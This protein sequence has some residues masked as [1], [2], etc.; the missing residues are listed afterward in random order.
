MNL[1]GNLTLSN[2][3]N[4]NLSIYFTDNTKQYSQIFQ[5]DPDPATYYNLGVVPDPSKP[6]GGIRLSL[7]LWNQSTTRWER[8]A[9]S[10]LSDLE[11]PDDFHSGVNALGSGVRLPQSLSYPVQGYA[12]ISAQIEVND[13]I[14]R[15]LGDNSQTAL[16]PSDGIGLAFWEDT[17]T[18]GTSAPANKDDLGLEGGNPRRNSQ[19]FVFKRKDG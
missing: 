7:Y 4:P 9:E 11:W 10:S 17:V 8:Q 19:L 2:N 14:V 16:I 1:S 12:A 5:L 3:A 13:S 15:V 18:Y 6:T